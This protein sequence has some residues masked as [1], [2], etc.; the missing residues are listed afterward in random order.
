MT[1]TAEPVVIDV[2]THTVKL[3]FA[4][5]SRPRAIL[6][7]SS[8]SDNWQLLWDLDFN[9]VKNDRVRKEKTDLLLARILALFRTIFHSH[10]MCD[11]KSRRIILTSDSSC[12]TIVTE[13]ILFVLL[14]RLHAPTVTPLPSP[15]LSLL[16]LG[17]PTGLFLSLGH[18]QASI[19]PIYHGSP[20]AQATVNSTRASGARLSRRLRAL[21]IAY[22]N[23][24]TSP[25]LFTSNR[26]ALAAA[27]STIRGNRMS[28]A[29]PPPSSQSASSSSASKVD[30]ASAIDID[31]LGPDFLEQC[32]VKA[33]IIA[34]PI[35]EGVE[36]LA[37]SLGSYP[38]SSK[39]T[40]SPQSSSTSTEQNSYPWN[41]QQQQYNTYS[42]S[43]YDDP[44]DYDSAFLDALRTRYQRHSP[45]SSS[46]QVQPLSIQLPHIPTSAPSNPASTPGT[47]RSAATAGTTTPN[48]TLTGSASA[49][50]TANSLL[51]PTQ[52]RVLVIPTWIRARC[53]EILFESVS[54]YSSKAAGDKATSADLDDEDEEEDTGIVELVLKSLNRA[55]LVLR[56]HL[57]SRIGVGGGTAQMFGLAHRVRIEVVRVLEALERVAW[58]QER[59]AAE[60]AAT[61]EQR[62][63][64]SAVGKKGSIAQQQKAEQSA[65]G[66]SHGYSID[67]E[68]AQ[69]AVVVAT[70]AT[71][72]PSQGTQP[73]S[74][75]PRR[76][77]RPKRRRTE[78]ESVLL[79][80][81]PLLPTHEL[82]AS[83]KRKYSH[84]GTLW[85]FV[86]VVND[87]RPPILPSSVSSSSSTGASRRRDVPVTVGPIVDEE[88]EEEQKRRSRAKTP[89]LD[90]RRSSAGE[91]GRRRSGG[92]RKSGGSAT[93]PAIEEEAEL[94]SPTTAPDVPLQ[95][96]SLGQYQHSS[97]YI[98]MYL[99]DE[100]QARLKAQEHD[101][102][103]NLL[104]PLDTD[105]SKPYAGIA[106]TLSPAL[107]PWIGGSLLGSLRGSS[108]S[109]LRGAKT[110]DLASMNAAAAS[111]FHWLSSNTLG[112][113]GEGSGKK[114]GD[115]ID[116]EAAALLGGKGSF[117]GVVGGLDTG[118]Y[119]GLA[120]VSRH[121]RGAWGAAAASPGSGGGGI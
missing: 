56:R 48:V 24:I 75:Q 113:G 54:S 83:W 106:P 120:A 63:K 112:H 60:K 1:S 49:A 44:L 73:S 69:P 9:R 4:G 78:A 52:Q 32:K 64:A 97:A 29:L 67:D 116:S 7:T 101:I 66:E 109:L 5:E 84:L 82:P 115:G 16:A 47:F 31:S 8:R 121:M 17:L 43:P 35:V 40:R 117:V 10:L 76:S 45:D 87:H 100:A 98:P 119:G 12:P 88:N 107:L 42:V 20:L 108:L 51:V 96:S 118:A 94:K 41:Q 39:P 81:V 72:H 55:P 22:G 2:G 65:E 25:P 15:F 93:S 104:Q 18:L 111:S 62:R 37:A 77:Q 110:W 53:A 92:S 80:D 59:E 71:P 13:A 86:R 105:R 38:S 33:L 27:A 68:T 103:Y 102:R 114:A 74:E 85:R 28:L 90:P 95:E 21:L 30:K 6:P 46:S 3:G 58:E 34:D 57:A 36:S 50:A 11:P 91:G 70:P 89:L 79:A 26:A 14:H 61:A 23:I 99:E 19:T